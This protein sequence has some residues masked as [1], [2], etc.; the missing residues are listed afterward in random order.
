MNVNSEIPGAPRAEIA[1]LMQSGLGRLVALRH[2]MAELRETLGDLGMLCDP[3]T[4]R[5]V[6]RLTAELD[7]HAP[8]ITMVGQIKSGKTSL[9]NAM[10]GRPG[11][12]PADVNP[13]TSVVT[14]LHVNERQAEGAPVASFQF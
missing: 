6:A 8:S 3:A 13:W 1:D 9:V 11:L 5:Q 10:V 12:L 2:E 4:E 14:S 7:A